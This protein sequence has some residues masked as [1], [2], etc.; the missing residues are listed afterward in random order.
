MKEV[1]GRETRTK[2]K[3]QDQEAV[4]YPSE[5]QGKR[6]GSSRGSGPPGPGGGSVC[7][8]LP[9]KALS[10]QA[11]LLLRK[12]P[13]SGGRER[14]VLAQSCH[15]LAAVFLGRYITTLTLVSSSGK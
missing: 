6:K 13:W 3:P 9:S 14:F 7:P 8:Q 10:V 1:R 11:A 4:C 2:V 5:V 12:E 15:F